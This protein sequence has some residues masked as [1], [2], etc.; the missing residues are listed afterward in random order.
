[1]DII[2]HFFFVG[3]YLIPLINHSLTHLERN[4]RY[5]AGTDAAESQTRNLVCL[6]T[7]QD[8]Q[9]CS[10]FLDD[11]PRFSLPSDQ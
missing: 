7:T 6:I 11:A 10:N 3:G 2:R 4:P 5:V 1:M 8:Y 9:N